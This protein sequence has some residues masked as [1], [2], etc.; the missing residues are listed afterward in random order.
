M[1]LPIGHEETTVRRMPVTLTIIGSC[2]VVF[3]LTAMAPSGEDRVAFA[4]QIAIEYFLDHPYL[5]LDE[6]HK[7]YTYYSLRQQRNDRQ[8]LRPGDL[9]ELQNEQRELDALVEAFH[10][11]R[12]G[13]PY[14]RW[15]LVPTDRDPQ[16]GSHRR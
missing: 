15:G 9:E 3:I 1:L 4:E 13:T 16:R 10:A 7:G 12:D 14:F 11:T 8:I 5:E 2:L 6:Q